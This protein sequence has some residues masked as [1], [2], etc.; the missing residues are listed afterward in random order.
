MDAMLWTGVARAL[1]LAGLGFAGGIAGAANAAA[2][3]ADEMVSYR[4][5]AGESL[6]AVSQR[7]LVGRTSYLSVQRLNRVSDA[8]A[9]APGTL[10]KIPTRLL[11]AVVIEQAGRRMAPALGMSIAQGAVVQTGAGFMTLALSNGS[12]VTLPSNS[13]VRI[14]H[15]RRFL[16]TNS[17]DFDFALDKGRAE[18]AVTPMK[19]SNSRFR[20]R[21]PIAVSAVRG[22]TFRIGYDEGKGPS[23]TEVI[24][25]GVAVGASASKA[26]PA[27]VPGGYGATAA[28][29][30]RVG[31]EQL[32]AAPAVLKPGRLQ[33]EPVVAFELADVPSARGYHVQLAKD[34]G[35][36][37]MIAETRTEGTKAQFAGIADGNYFVRAMAIAPS[38]LQGLSESYGIKRQL[39]AL[40]G[41]AASNAPGQ[42]GFKWFGEGSGKR[43][44]RFQLLTRP[45]GGV[46]LVDETGLDKNEI[47]VSGLTPGVYYW[48][49]GVRQ[50]GE[51]GVAEN[52]T[53]AEKFTLAAPE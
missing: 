44:Y 9:I 40:G 2:P 49:V 33:K 39:T 17:L 30:G 41:A 6:Y 37:D 19:D 46:P 42:F 12:R 4:I 13:R 23:L 24:E 27:L 50:F 14:L 21:T 32:L 31:T 11:R 28:A 53:P 10:I 22:T 26:E 52:W 5:K 45:E 3:V 7:Y 36:V 18:T 16:L 47:D 20:L 1:A 38:G 15:M 29:D 25:G 8:H 35:F 48:R 43:V 34:A 51:S